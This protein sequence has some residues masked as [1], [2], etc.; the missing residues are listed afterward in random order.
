M[1]KLQVAEKVIL[2]GVQYEAFSKELEVLQNISKSGE[3][4]SRSKA[5]KMKDKIKRTSSLYR[6]DPFLDEKGIVR[7]GGTVKR[8]N[9][10]IELKNP[11]IL[12]RKGHVTDII[13]DIITTK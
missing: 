11:V 7:V 10:S 6:L 13:L 5:K 3:E 12:P 1:S 8:A 4:L 2:Q 9:V